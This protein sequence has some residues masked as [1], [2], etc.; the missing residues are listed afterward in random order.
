EIGRLQAGFVLCLSRLPEIDE[1]L[2]LQ[3][4]IEAQRRAGASDE[5]LWHGVARTLLN[6][7]ELI[8]RE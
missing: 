5:A 4:L 6:L 7:D 3:E 8:T 2:V 1:L